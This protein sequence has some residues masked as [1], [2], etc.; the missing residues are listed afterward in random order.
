MHRPT[1]GGSSLKLYAVADDMYCCAVDVLKPLKFKYMSL[2]AMR[3]TSFDVDSGM[4]IPSVEAFQADVDGC[5]PIFGGN[6]N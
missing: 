5:W 1:A 6:S 4:A 2:F 3:T